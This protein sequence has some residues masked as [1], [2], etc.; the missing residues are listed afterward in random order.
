[1]KRETTEDKSKLIE[2]VDA[3]ILRYRKA[4]EGAKAMLWCNFAKLV[5]AFAERMLRK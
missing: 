3:E 2:T 5:E 4:V 1:M